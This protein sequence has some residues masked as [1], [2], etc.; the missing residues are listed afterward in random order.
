MSFSACRH[1]DMLSV[2]ISSQMFRL[3]LKRIFLSAFHRIVSGEAFVEKLLV[4]RR[5]AGFDH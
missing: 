5:L 4:N 2:S 3:E 1:V